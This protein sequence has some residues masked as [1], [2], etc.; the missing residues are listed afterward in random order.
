[1]T[2]RMVALAAAIGLTACNPGGDGAANKSANAAAK[3]AA[4][5]LKRPTYCFFKDAA[6]KAWAAS[7]DASGNVMVKGKVKLDDRRYRGDMTQSEV[8]GATARLWVTMAPNTTGMGAVENWWDV[9]LTIPGSGAVASVTVL[10]GTKT[11]AKLVVA[12]R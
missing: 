7:V 1:M 12:R 11:V 3:A 8:A 4:P 10:C 5:G 2:G 6:T 9:N